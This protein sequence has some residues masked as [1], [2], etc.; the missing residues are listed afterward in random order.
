MYRQ[1]VLDADSKAIQQ[2][3]FVEQLKNIIGIKAHG[4][5]FS[6]NDFKQD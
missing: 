6:F 3:E 4:I 5:S 1:K 2:T